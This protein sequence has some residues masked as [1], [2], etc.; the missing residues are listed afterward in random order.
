MPTTDN[1]VLVKSGVK[2]HT[3]ALTM[4]FDCL[5]KYGT[6]CYKDFNEKMSG[7]KLQALRCATQGL[8]CNCI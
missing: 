7:Q 3:G 1:L 2:W 5:V 4:V 6:Q 8:F